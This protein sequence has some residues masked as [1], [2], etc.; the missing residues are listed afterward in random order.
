MFKKTKVCTGA[1]VALGG[2]LLATSMPVVA[3]TAERIEIT[4]SRI[5]TLGAVS[6]SPISSVS[7]AD[8]NTTQPVAVEEVVRSL[9]A[10]TP[11]IG[12]NTNNGSGGGATIQLRGLGT[13]RTLVLVNGR[14]MVPFNLAGVVDTNSIP[15]SLLERV[16]IVTGGASAVYGADAVAGVVNFV[17]RK[18]FQGVEASGSYGVSEEGDAKRYRT[19]L[20]LGAGFAEGKGNVALSVGQAKTNPLTQGERPFS[21]FSIT[22]TSGN[23]GGSG[24]TVPSAFTIA[25]PSTIPAADWNAGLNGALPG[26]RQINPATGTLGAANAVTPYNFNPPNYFI[27]PLDRTQMTALAE[28]T[29]NDYAQVYA[30]L[31]YTRSKVELNLAATGTFNNLYDVPIGNP[32]IPAAMRDQLCAAYQIAAAGCVA[33]AGGTTIVQMQIN[34]RIT[35]IGPR[36]NDFDNETSQYTVGVKGTLPFL[37][38]WGYDA[39]MSSG[40]AFQV[41]TRVNWGSLARSRQALNALSTTACTNTANGCVPLNVFGAEGSI[42]PAML[43]F[44]NVNAIQQQTVTQK[45]YSASFSGDLGFIKSPLAKAPISLAIG[46]EQ[47]TTFGGNASDGPSQIQGEVL[48][49]GAPLPDR[50]GTLKLDEGFFEA[51]IPVLADF[52]GAKSL[53]LEAGF[54]STKFT[55]GNASKNYDSWKYGGEWT[56]IKGLRFRAMK[57]RATRAPNVNE[58][59]APVVSGLANLQVDPCAGTNINAAAAGTAGTLSNLCVQ[60]GVPLGQVGA[61]P[62]PSAGQINVVAGGN[63]NLG[64]EEADTSTVGFV[65]EPDFVPGLSV[66]LDY[67]QITINKSV[68]A[69]TAPQVING[70]YTTALNPGLGFNSLCGLIGRSPIDGTFNGGTAPG[71]NTST[72][73]LGTDWTAGYDLEVR[74]RLPLRSLGLDAKW[75]RVDLAL[76]ANQVTKYEFQTI[77]GVPLLDCLGYYGTSC[78]GPN[79]KTKFTQRG[80]WNVG[81]WNFAYN[82][83]YVGKVIEEPGGTVYRPEFSTVKAYSYVDL[84]M[85]WNV[86][87]N[88]KLKLS[89]ANA[90]D[91]KPPEVGSTIGT[92]ATNSGN[93]FP[94][95]YDVVGRAYT[96]GA[97]LK[98]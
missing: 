53:N 65:F 77:P 15:V 76:S 45:V 3:Q 58:L 25:R 61:V 94:S 64:P 78:G 18:N 84:T 87:K 35:E 29:I 88:L 9:P 32:Y 47:R 89:V 28:Y 93:T 60:T 69:A 13:N 8:L 36:I 57:Q 17:L 7:A 55:S 11:A 62:Q 72:S 22:S 44:F 31:F 85:D 16:D 81:D 48:G 50:N 46:A 26:S 86:T 38:N 27:T 74:Y 79:Y 37:T 59:Y 98:F 71:V 51:I 24:T 90:F 52:P 95:Y 42:T 39:Y 49:T 63:P 33:G 21:I 83:K 68:S 6:N 80:S 82:W 23:P 54:R 96:I 30:D 14:R 92:T 19:D 2:A 12:A 34:R 5:R 1:L 73:N 70:C 75:G 66:S 56:P 67:Y 91:K 41:S 10:T 20:T 40:R 4:G 43:A 97:T